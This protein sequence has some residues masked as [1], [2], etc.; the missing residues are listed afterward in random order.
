MMGRTE[1]LSPHELERAARLLKDGQLVAFPT[2]TVYGL[3]ACL[4]NPDAIL[5]IF[6]AK[7]RPSDNPLIAHLSHL[8]QVEE[9]AEEIPPA[10]YRLAEHFIPGPLTVVLK[11]RAHVPAIVS[12]GLDTIALRLPS[13]PVAR[14]LITCVGSRSSRRRRTFRASPARRRPNTFWTILTAGSQ[15]SSTEERRQWASNLPS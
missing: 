9:I 14:A 7:G 15:P 12:A 5:S 2:E 11:R 4:F 1:V 13:H 3:G 8:G 10:F 6:K